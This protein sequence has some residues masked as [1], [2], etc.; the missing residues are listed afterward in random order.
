MVKTRW[1]KIG[2]GLPNLYEPVLVHISNDLIRID[3][4]ITARYDGVKWRCECDCGRKFSNKITH[5]SYLPKKPHARGQ[6]QKTLNKIKKEKLPT[7][8]KKMDF[9]QEQLSEIKRIIQERIDN[10]SLTLRDIVAE[11]GIKYGV[12]YQF[13]KKNKNVAKKNGLLINKY[14]NSL[15]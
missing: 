3:H 15:K 11:I 4:V 2:Q 1:I 12:F 8:P 7:G 13:F 14:Y 9:T 5:W 6:Y 10:N